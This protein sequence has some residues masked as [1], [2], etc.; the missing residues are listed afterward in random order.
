MLKLKY[1]CKMSN[2]LLFSFVL[3]LALGGSAVQAQEQ[4]FFL[5]ASGSVKGIYFPLAA[6][7]CKTIN[8]R[9]LN[10]G[11]RC[12]LVATGGS[13][14]NLKGVVSGDYAF[15]IVQSNLLRSNGAE[16]EDQPVKV[17]ASLYPEPIHI[18]VRE[19][20]EIMTLSDLDGAIVNFGDEGSGTLSLAEALMKAADLSVPPSHIRRFG[21]SEQTA[22]IC[23]GSLDALIWV[24][25]LRNSA[26]SEA[27]NRCALRLIP[28][29]EN[30]QQAMIRA[31]PSLE[32]MQI[33]AGTYRTQ[34]RPVMTVGPY[35]RIVASENTSNALVGIVTETLLGSLS[36][37]RQIHPT[38]RELSQTKLKSLFPGEELHSG[39]SSD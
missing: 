4:R 36:D 9:A 23:N 24:S 10:R 25:G 26:M 18:V 8:R 2:N 5:F 38:L 35:A 13:V 30:V 32:L 22:K 39:A 29:D 27:F 6:H 16:N 34:E 37:V 14:D 31:D 19:P 20:S 1:F 12:G 7:I 3:S 21:A 15:A 11:L 33:P 17:V 28:L